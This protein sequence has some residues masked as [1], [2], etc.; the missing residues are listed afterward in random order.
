MK[1]VGYVRVS[2]QGQAD[3]GVSLESQKAKIRAFCDLHD[4][5]LT[6][7]YEDA[8]I[9]G[10]KADREGL[11]GAMA[12]L[13]KG[14]VLVVYSMSRLSRNAAH[15]LALSQLLEKRGIDLA[16]LSENIDTSTAAG[17]MY[18][19]VSAAFNQ[20]F[21]D[22]IAENTKAAL[23]NKK[24]NN[25]KYSPVPFGYKEVEGRLV[26]VKKEAMVVAEI[27]K[28]REQGH[29]LTSIADRLNDRGLQGKKGGRWYA[30][31]ISYII[32]RQ[33]A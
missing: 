11:Q 15:M 25:E 10:T 33:A 3:D 12:A 14:S 19:T 30:S 32:K 17:K 18:F 5:E 20:L 4:Y 23:A 31:T 8:G 16:S 27:L 24:A 21:R 26:E 9:S 7:I 6:G 1:A 13:Q 22:Q 29:T 28:L 2:T